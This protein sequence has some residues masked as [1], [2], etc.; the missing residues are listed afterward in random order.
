MPSPSRP[1]GPAPADLGYNSD[2][3][4][5]AALPHCRIAVLPA[6]CFA[7]GP[8]LLAG[9]LC[10]RACF[11]G[12]PALP[13]ACCAGGPAVPAGL[14]GPSQ[15]ILSPSRGAHRSSFPAK[16]CGAAGRVRIVQ[17]PR[18]VIGAAA[19]DRASSAP[20]RAG[21]ASAPAPPPPRCSR[22]LRRANRIQSCRLAVGSQWPERATA[23]RRVSVLQRGAP[24]STLTSTSSVAPAASAAADT[25]ATLPASSTSTPILARRASAASR[26]SLPVPTL[27]VPGRPR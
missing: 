12:G 2:P 5:I 27:R 18:A 11:A 17:I 10:W 16:P 7:G 26:R 15:R 8:A 4:R 20:I 3:Y 22:R 25:S 21:Q 13:A 23:A 24:T 9:L 6:G 19:H 1:A 14:D